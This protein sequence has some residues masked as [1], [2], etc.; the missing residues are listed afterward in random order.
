MH[1]IVS[2]I[3]KEELSRQEQL[4]YDRAKKLQNFLTQPFFSAEIYSGKKGAYVRLPQTIEGCEQ[5]I[6]GK[7]DGVPEQKFYMIGTLETEE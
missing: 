7:M 4:T 1:R 6:S 3:G 2:I 5:I